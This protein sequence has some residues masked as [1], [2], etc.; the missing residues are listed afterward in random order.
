M[1]MSCGVIAHSDELTWFVQL[2]SDDG[3]VLNAYLTTQEVKEPPLGRERR[4]LSNPQAKADGAGMP[5]V[6]ANQT[7]R[8]L[9]AVTLDG[10]PVVISSG[11]DRRNP[12]QLGE[13]SKAW[14]GAYA[15]KTCEVKLNFLSAEL[16]GELPS[17]PST[18][19][20]HPDSHLRTKPGMAPCSAPLYKDTGA[21]GS[22][23][24]GEAKGSEAVWG[25]GEAL[26]SEAFG[27]RGVA[28]GSGL[29]TRALRARFVPAAAR[30]RKLLGKQLGSFLRND[31]NDKPQAAGRFAARPRIGETCV[32]SAPSLA[33][34]TI[35]SRIAARLVE[36]RLL[37]NLEPQQQNGGYEFI[38]T[39]TDETSGTY[40][41]E[42][43]SNALRSNK[44][45]NGMSNF[46]V[47]VLLQGDFQ[48]NLRDFSR[49]ADAADAVQVAAVLFDLLGEEPSP[50][51]NPWLESPRGWKR[52]CVGKDLAVENA[53]NNF[54]K[55][56]V[57]N[58]PGLWFP[59]VL[60]RKL[61]KENALGWEVTSLDLEGEPTI[62]CDILDWDHTAFPPG[63]FQVVWASPVCCEFSKALTRRPRRL[64]SLV[65]R[66]LELINYFKRN[67]RAG[68]RLYCSRFIH[69]RRTV[70]PEADGAH[71]IPLLGVLQTTMSRGCLTS[72]IVYR[73]AISSHSS[74]DRVELLL[75]VAAALRP[76]GVAPVAGSVPQILVRFR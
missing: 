50:G 54:D 75:A 56:L 47:G 19:G 61:Y 5:V 55:P 30:H 28:L 27:G 68:S 45:R 35:S 70:F 12:L 22:N 13:E 52:P 23:G 60:F 74:G 44:T 62:R 33:W 72:H 59:H 38:K 34:N 10:F 6:L 7:P 3:E 17:R 53:Q 29:G 1:L 21:V 51:N 15:C 2:N 26:H 18:A 64:D 49:A 57:G 42:N 40:T 25:G 58:K 11:A 48:K 66:T 65:L 36:E 41:E 31:K 43:M 46:S 39:N 4:T 67:R 69:T 73:R 20:E 9:A 63:H 14:D 71:S 24:R 16:D 32:R 76:G 8:A 37:H